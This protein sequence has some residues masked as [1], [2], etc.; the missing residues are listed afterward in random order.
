MEFDNKIHLIKTVPNQNSDLVCDYSL[1]Q[2]SANEKSEKRPFAN[3]YGIT[4]ALIASLSLSMANVLFKKAHF[5]S[6]FDLVLIRY[7]IQLVI[8]LFL[9]SERHAYVCEGFEISM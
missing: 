6:G 8:A 5:F 4:F 9:A 3:Y 7:I 1:I 2:N